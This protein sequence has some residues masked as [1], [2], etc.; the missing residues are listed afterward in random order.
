[1]APPTREWGVGRSPSK[2]KV[3]GMTTMGVTAMIASTMPV[4]VVSSAHCMTLTP[5]VWPA[6]LLARTQGHTPRHF[7]FEGA[8]TGALGDADSIGRCRLNAAFLAMT[9]CKAA[10]D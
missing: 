4:G 1:M 5:M 10:G 2:A 9:C 3:K 7:F 6:R 8:M